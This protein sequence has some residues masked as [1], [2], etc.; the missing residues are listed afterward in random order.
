[1]SEAVDQQG[2]IYVPRKIIIISLIVHVTLPMLYLGVVGLE[3]LGI[4]LF[5]ASKNPVEVYQN[6]IQVDMVAL[7]DELMNQKVDIDPTL[8][9][10]EK[11]SSAQEQ[12]A[13]QEEADAMHLAE[14]K[15]AAEKAKAEK[16]KKA[17]EAAEKKAKI[18]K[19][20]ALKAMEREAEKE[21]ALK[22]LKEKAGE[23]GRQKISG[24]L[25]SKGTAMSGKV[26]TAKDRYS[27]LVAMKIRENFNIFPWQK[28][29]GLATNVYIE[30]TAQGRIKEKKLM[31]QSRDPVFDAAVLQAIEA[32]QPLPVPEDMSLVSDG[33]Q[34]EFRP[35]N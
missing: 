22:G 5:P 35:E 23:K 17:T 26:G 12:V 20:K 15:A 21:N 25:L 9:I 16:E 6:F 32:S 3:K 4:K 34:L 28:K 18:E 24:N 27:A 33:I 8:P 7:P 29:K 10:V 2:F 14:E 30:I 13:A 11:A 31:K 19:E 1:M